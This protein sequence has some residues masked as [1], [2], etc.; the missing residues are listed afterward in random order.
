MTC[1]VYDSPSSSPCNWDAIKSNSEDNLKRST[2]SALLNLRLRHKPLPFTSKIHMVIW[3]HNSQIMSEVTVLTIQA[4]KSR[5][6]EL[7]SLKINHIYNV[8]KK[9]TNPKKNK[10]KIVHWNYNLPL[11]IHNNVK[12]KVN[13]V[14]IH[15]S[16]FF[17]KVTTIFI[18][19][20]I[21]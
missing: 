21:V 12:I 14:K 18:I 20:E 10:S 6:V 15:T 5:A 16:V 1:E 19:R 13:I 4:Q 8:S 2:T 7:I 17:Y 9:Y 3:L 11:Y